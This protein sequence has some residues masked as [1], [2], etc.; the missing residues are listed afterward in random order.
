MFV[1]S[2]HFPFL[3]ASEN[4]GHF[5][6]VFPSTLLEDDDENEVIESLLCS[7]C[8]EEKKG[9][10]STESSFFPSVL[11]TTAKSIVPVDTGLS[12]VL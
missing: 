3:D 6:Y 7:F 4:G 2:R 5:F 12:N 9:F 1:K 10:L 11:I 8:Y